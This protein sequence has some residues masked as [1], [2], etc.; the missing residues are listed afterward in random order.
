M[1]SLVM[2]LCSC[3]LPVMSL[4]TITSFNLHSKPGFYHELAIALYIDV[5]HDFI[6][7]NP[8]VCVCV[9]VFVCV[10]ACVRVCVYAHV[11]ACVHSTHSFNHATDTHK[12]MYAKHTIT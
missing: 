6:L 4:N 8:S 12:R 9:C 10:C 5:I 7:P 11:C 2:S 3:N 1:C